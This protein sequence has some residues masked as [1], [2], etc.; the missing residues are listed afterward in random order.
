VRH[1]VDAGVLRLENARTVA[2][3]RTA[4]QPRN[5]Q[6]GGAAGGGTV[7]YVGD[8]A[9]GTDRL[10]FEREAPE[11]VASFTIYPA[12]PTNRLR[13]VPLARLRRLRRGDSPGR[14]GRQ[15]LFVARLLLAQGRPRAA[16]Q[17]LWGGYL[18]PLRRAL[19]G[20]AGT[21][22]ATRAA[23]EVLPEGR[24]RIAGQ[25]AGPAGEV[26]DWA[27]GVTLSREVALEGA[28][29]RLVDRLADEEAGATGAPTVDRVVYL[30]PDTARDV[31]IAASDG[32]RRGGR[33]GRRLEM[34]PAGR[35]FFLRVA[36]AV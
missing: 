15:W 5:T 23:L 6:W 7:V 27:S 24:L 30:L 36:Y 12:R 14:E 8:T 18:G 28:E 1:F 17:R 21:H 9:T 16:W 25:P 29:V 35:A 19:A 20:P 34:R 10:R 4:K 33:G 13:P 26:P 22:W 11:G 32:V 31:R 3:L 2:L